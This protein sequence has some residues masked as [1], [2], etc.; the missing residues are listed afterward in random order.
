MIRWTDEELNIVAKAMAKY[1]LNNPGES[2]PAAYNATKECL[3]KSRRRVIKSSSNFDDSI[4]PMIKS[5]MIPDKAKVP[6]VKLIEKVVNI[7]YKISDIPTE[8]LQTEIHRRQFEP[9]IDTIT[10]KV[11][12][13]ILSSLPKIKSNISNP[14]PD[15]KHLKKILIVGLLPEQQNEISKEFKGIYDLRYV[16][17]ESI[18]QIKSIASNC[19]E[20]IL[21]TKFIGHRHQ[22][23][24]KSSGVIYSYCNG[25]VS[26]L[27][28]ILEATFYEKGH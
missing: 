16:K 24:A 7:P 18:H 1:L 19:D 11:I 15:K 5:H 3:P 25:A 21:M 17:D 8:E 12:S 6:E 14:K 10:N 4:I 22:D 9:I 27:K 23:A 13:K 2:L 28:E 20:I 26:E